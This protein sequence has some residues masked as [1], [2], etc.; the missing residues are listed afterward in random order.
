MLTLAHS[1]YNIGKM[2]EMLGTFEQAVCLAIVRLRED[3]Y[4][5]GIRWALRGFIWGEMK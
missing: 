5:R 2:L 3:E 4:G 1:A